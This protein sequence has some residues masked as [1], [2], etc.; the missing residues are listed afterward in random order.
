MTTQ[1]NMLKVTLSALGIRQRDFAADGS[2]PG[3]QAGKRSRFANGKPVSENAAR[4]TRAQWGKI[5]AQHKEPSELA[6]M[7]ASRHMKQRDFA[8]DGDVPGGQPA[9]SNFINGQ[10][11]S[12]NA[13]RAIRAHWGTLEAGRMTPS[14]AHAGVGGQPAEEEDPPHDA[15]EEEPVF[16][17]HPVRHNADLRKLTMPDLARKMQAYGIAQ[18]QIDQLARWARVAMVR[19]LC[20][21]AHSEGTAGSDGRYAR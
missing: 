20:S 4:A 10:H 12:E 16:P 3:G 6:G 15:A 7:L 17:R 18:A 9:V 21:N 13:A 5:E 8:N 19:E 2:V 1:G 11:V 14:D